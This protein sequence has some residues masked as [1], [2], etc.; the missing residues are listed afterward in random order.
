MINRDFGYT[1]HPDNFEFIEGVFDACKRFQAQ[2]YLLVVVT[3][4]SGIAR[5]YYTEEEFFSLTEW[6]LEAFERH[7]VDISR[8][9]Y[10]PH[11]PTAGKGKYLQVCACRKPEPGMLLQAAE[12][13]NIELSE[14]IIIGDSLTDIQAGENAGLKEGI[15]ID[16]D[17]KY[18][19]AAGKMKIFAKLGDVRL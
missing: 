4:Q 11:H 10:C 7:G 19:D 14:S 3:N 2:G 8:V 13:L 18:S 17:F 5:G 9:Y 1:S 6:M 15:L 16:E 12:E